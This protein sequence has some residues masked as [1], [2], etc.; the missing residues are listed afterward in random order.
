MFLI[1]NIYIALSIVSFF[2]IAARSYLEYE[3]LYEASVSLITNKFYSLFTINFFV[4]LTLLSVNLLIL[5][6]FGSFK[7]DKQKI[8]E[9][10]GDLGSSLFFNMIFLSTELEK[11]H[12]GYVMIAIFLPY[13]LFFVDNKINLFYVTAETPKLEVHKRVMKGQII[14]LFSTF[15][16]LVRF[17]SYYHQNGSQILILLSRQ[18]SLSL[19]AIIKNIIQH[20][21]FIV[22]RRNFG[23]SKSSCKINL[24]TETLTEISRLMVNIIFFGHFVVRCSFGLHAFMIF[25]IIANLWKLITKVMSLIQYYKL[26]NDLRVVLPAPSHEDLTKDSTCIICRG[27]MSESDSKKLPCGHC[28]HL[29]CIERW[30]SQQQKCPICKTD[31]P[32]YI[33]LLSS[34][35]DSHPRPNTDTQQ[36]P[37]TNEP[38]QNLNNKSIEDLKT[39]LIN[40]LLLQQQQQTEQQQNNQTQQQQNNQTM[41]LNRNANSNDLHQVQRSQSHTLGER[42]GNYVGDGNLRRNKDEIVHQLDWM[43]EQMKAFQEEIARIKNDIENQNI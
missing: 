6:F 25:N 3:N 26:L 10:L 13:I 24:T 21:V 2:S 16:L 4:A 37:E 19:P 39:L 20:I 43:L 29:D 5:F 36:P 32:S 33:K 42:N 34:K 40:Q 11:R 28:F 15:Y 12:I 22:D 14:L 35:K 18:I 27:T 7:N 1:L 17:L 23:N 9:F 8:P 41:N 38:L 31:L 30:I